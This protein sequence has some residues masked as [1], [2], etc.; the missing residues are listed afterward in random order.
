MCGSGDG[1]LTTFNIPGKKLYVQ[2]YTY[3]LEAAY[4]L[5]YFSISITKILIVGR[6]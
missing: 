6:I 3:L 2:V 4:C 5:I 1:S